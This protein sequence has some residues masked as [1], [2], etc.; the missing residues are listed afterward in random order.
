MSRERMEESV[1]ARLRVDERRLLE[2]MAA[3]EMRNVSD[4]TRIAIIE[5]AR[6]RGLWPEERREEGAA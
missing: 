2:C 4:M 5:A 6:S 3:Q 1:T